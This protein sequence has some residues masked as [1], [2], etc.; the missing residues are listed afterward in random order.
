MPDE[1]LTSS[2]EWN[3]F[4]S[5]SSSRLHSSDPAG[6]TDYSSWSS[7]ELNL[8]QWIQADLGSIRVLRA[9]AT[10]G[11]HTSHQWVTSYKLSLNYGAGFQ[12]VLNDDDGSER[13]FLG[14]Q[15][16]NTVVRN[17]LDYVQASSVKLHP[18]SW[19]NH[20]SLRWELY[21]DSITGESAFSSLA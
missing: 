21:E 13:M 4:L 9:V 12:F 10:Q 7:L 19:Y 17:C 8:D 20:I 6:G 1:A 18:Q 14:N 15:D 11:R 5:V 3:E 16:S 2:S